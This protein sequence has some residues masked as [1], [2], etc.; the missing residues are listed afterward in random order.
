MGRV[1]DH[2][3]TRVTLVSLCLYAAH[4]S[5]CP[6]PVPRAGPVSVRVSVLRVQAQLG[7]Q[8]AVWKTHGV[9]KE[10]TQY[11]F[12]HTTLEDSKQSDAESQWRTRVVLGGTSILGSDDI[13]ITIVITPHR[14]GAR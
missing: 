2:P 3:C 11:I 7:H 10:V 13:F 8:C 14:V 4:V 6:S 5:L 12:N 9:L 1:Y